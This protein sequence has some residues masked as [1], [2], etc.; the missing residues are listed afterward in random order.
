MLQDVIVY[1]VQVHASGSRY[2]PM[3][4]TCSSQESRILNVQTVV[5]NTKSSL[6]LSKFGMLYNCKSNTIAMVYVRSI[7]INLREA[8]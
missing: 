7:N 2:P 4:S 1:I 3:S 5:N 8:R 6:L